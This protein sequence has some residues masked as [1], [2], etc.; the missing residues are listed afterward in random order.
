[1]RESHTATV[2]RDVRGPYGG[3]VDLRATLDELIT[4]ASLPPVVSAHT[5]G[6]QGF[7]NQLLAGVLGS[8]L[9]LE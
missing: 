2:L 1:M 4:A 8:G 6:E 9:R 7:D 5:L 3:G